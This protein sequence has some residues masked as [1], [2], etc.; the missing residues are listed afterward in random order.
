MKEI[1][2]YRTFLKFSHCLVAVLV[3]LAS[4]FSNIAL[5]QEKKRV[6]IIHADELIQKDDIKDAQ[7]LVGHVQLMHNGAL[8]FCD[9]SYVYNT[10]NNMD[11]Y[12]NVTINQGDTVLLH[13]NYLFYNGNLRQAIAVGNVRLINIRQ[14]TTLTSD[15]LNYDLENNI[16]YYQ[17]YGQIVDST[18][19][20]TSI[21]GQYFMNQDLAYFYKDV[22]VQNEDFTLLSDTL[23]YNTSTNIISIEGPTTIWDSLTT[24]YAEDGWYNS[25]T[26]E[27]ELIK[28]TFIQNKEQ[29]IRGDTIEY[30][31]KAGKGHAYGSVELYDQEKQIKVNGNFVVYD[32]NLNM[33]LVTDSAL[34]TLYSKEDTLYLH[35]DTL[36][37][38]PDTV[39]DEKI[40]KAY[41]SVRFF[42]NDIQGNC[43]S[44]VYYTKDSTIFLHTNPI[45]WSGIRQM[46]ADLIE[47]KS[48]ENAPNQVHMNNNSFIISKRDTIMFDQ[49]KGK[50]MVGYVQDGTLQKID[51]EGNGQTL[52]YAVDKNETVGLNGAESSKIQ[53]IFKEGA[54]HRI[55]FLSNPEGVL[56]PLGQLEDGQRRLNGFGWH[57]DRRPLTK[58][59][60]FKTTP[61]AKNP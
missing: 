28:N 3:I 17:D 57:A 11:A 12:G 10:S 47:M 23:I 54:V 56:N 36:T 20:L 48:Y 27:S 33:S 37:S 52:Y 15:T 25:I 55:K 18:N 9:S 59:D 26:G 21:I 31:K 44:L 40:V 51:V 45:L 49:I 42:R 22:K 14:G 1:F 19:T 32:D 5:A 24:I 30:F 38:I 41:H 58:D 16:A 29:S 7:R 2:P 46:T 50:K 35:A 4:W 60:V 39:M 6:E 13:S 53:I 8:M 61:P 34:L 43:D